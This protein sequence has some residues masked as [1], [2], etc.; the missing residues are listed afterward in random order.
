MSEHFHV[1]VPWASEHSVDKGPCWKHVNRNASGQIE[2]LEMFSGACLSLAGGCPPSSPRW[3]AVSLCL[4]TQVWHGEDFPS[5]IDIQCL[6]AAVRVQEGPAGGLR[7]THRRP[8]GHTAG[9]PVCVWYRQ[10]R[11]TAGHHH[12]QREQQ[13]S[14]EALSRLLPRLSKVQFQI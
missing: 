4:E 13:L 7:L 2:G 8:A 3:A 9:H 10:G 1:S 14:S 5:F 6:P 11:Q 12:H